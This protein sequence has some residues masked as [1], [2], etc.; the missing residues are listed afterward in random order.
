MGLGVG[1]EK[2]ESVGHN[3][4]DIDDHKQNLLPSTKQIIALNTLEFRKPHHIHCSHLIV[5]S[6]QGRGLKDHLM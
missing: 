2:K 1:C 4:M 6:S 5:Q 3:Q